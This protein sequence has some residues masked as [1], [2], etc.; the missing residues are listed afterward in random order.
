M[1][2]A[3]QQPRF[4]RSKNVTTLIQIHESLQQPSSL[5]AAGRLAAGMMRVRRDSNPRRRHAVTFSHLGKLNSIDASHI[6]DLMQCFTT[7]AAEISSCDAPC[8][9]GL[10]ESGIIPSFAMHRACLAQ[11]RSA[12][13][14]CTSRTDQGGLCFRE[15]HSHA[16]RHFLPADLFAKPIAEMWVVEDEITTGRTLLNLLDCI[17]QTRG[18]DCVRVFTL[19][20]TRDQPEPDQPDR[21][22]QWVARAG[23][24]ANMT[25]SVQSVLRTN[26]GFWNDNVH[27]VEPRQRDDEPRQFVAG[28]SLA[29][30]LPSLLSGSLP[31]L[32]HVT[33]SPWMIDGY[34]VLSRQQMMP[35]YYLY[36]ADEC[37]GV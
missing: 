10:A 16:P 25:V 22:Q 24:N 12:R 13:W 3:C 14:F 23:F 37:C 21:I 1:P 27:P 7:L 34:H 17:H 30:V 15:P 35:G 36:N 31:R 2:P 18:L 4:K 6:H 8:I 5:A 33:L 19:L 26:P 20:D 32:Q 28:E 9:I 11:G 29:G